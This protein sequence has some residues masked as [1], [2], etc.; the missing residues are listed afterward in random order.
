M[1]AHALGMD[2]TAEGIETKEQ[3]FCIKA[4]KCKYVQG[5]FFSK[6]VDS[7]TAGELIA[8]KLGNVHE[9]LFFVNSK[10]LTNN[11]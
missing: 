11:S 5:Y 8:Q 7:A 10:A 9:Q 4:L 2:V 3:L 1:M 6:P